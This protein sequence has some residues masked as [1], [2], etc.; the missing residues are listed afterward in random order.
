MGLACI[1]LALLFAKP[2]VKGGIWC[3]SNR[4]KGWSD[5]KFLL[6]KNMINSTYIWFRFI[7]VKLEFPDSS[8]KDIE[9]NNFPFLVPSCWMYVS[10]RHPACVHVHAPTLTSL[11]QCP[12]L[13]YFVFCSS[14][15]TRSL[16]RGLLK[17]Y[18]WKYIFCWLFFDEF[19]WG[20][21]FLS[22]IWI[23]FSG[24]ISYFCIAINC[25]YFCLLSFIQKKISSGLDRQFFI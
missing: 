18:N 1:S 15:N 4:K 22:I 24:N 2:K 13:V 11:V 16:Q 19:D 23:W 17:N 14:H 10:T 9:K 12:C 21:F 5:L 8:V 25:I 6:Q 20:C 7:L 3:L